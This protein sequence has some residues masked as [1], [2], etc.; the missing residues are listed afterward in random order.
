MRLRHRTAVTTFPTSHAMRLRLCSCRTP[1]VWVLPLLKV[2]EEQLFNICI[3]EPGTHQALKRP[4]ELVQWH[5]LSISPKQM[6]RGIILW[7]GGTRSREAKRWSQLKNVVF[8]VTHPEQGFIPGP[9]PTCHCCPQPLCSTQIGDCVC[10][11]A[12][13]LSH[14]PVPRHRE[15]SSLPVGFPPILNEQPLDSEKPAPS[16]QLFWILSAS[17]GPANPTSQGA[18]IIAPCVSV[19]ACYH[20]SLE[21]WDSYEIPALPPTSWAVTSLLWAS[22]SSPLSGKNKKTYFTE[23]L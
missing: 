12:P 9:T 22:V 17:N 8:D 14:L 16:P 5:C 20:K 3:P 23:Q 1:L 4:T 15:P 18:L 6:L 11:H 19:L 7:V 21:D 10:D 13:S 2:P